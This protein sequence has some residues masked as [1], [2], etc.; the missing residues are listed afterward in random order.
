MI[1]HWSKRIKKRLT[2]TSDSL[3]KIGQHDNFTHAV[4]CCYFGRK[5]KSG[6]CQEPIRLQ[7]SLPCPLV[8]RKKK[9]YWTMYLITMYDH[10]HTCVC[11]RN[12][13]QYKGPSFI[14]NLYQ[15]EKQKCIRTLQLAWEVYLL[16]PDR[17]RL[18]LHKGH[19][20]T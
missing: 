10:V 8:G 15:L 2:I 14:A 5:G 17:I 12:C 13:E 3:T 6:P 19:P 1:N 11:G 18:Q 9:H 4:S 20:I 16:F 7:D